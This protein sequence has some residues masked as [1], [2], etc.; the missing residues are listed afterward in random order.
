MENKKPLC[1]TFSGAIGSSKTPIA[2]YLSGK[3]NL[4]V[5][6]N[7]ALRSEIIGD[8][9]F[10]DEK[11]HGELKERRIK[12]ILE[13]RISFICDASVDRQWETL[14]SWLQKYDYDFFIISLDLSKDF[15][16][17]LHKNK[18]KYE[19]L[20]RLD[21]FMADHNLFIDKHADEISLHI[22][23]SNFKDRLSLAYK[24]V[25]EVFNF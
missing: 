15:L 17:K 5:F 3:L 13:K 2:N 1:I 14:K 12:E 6:N 25:S 20:L 9:G 4:P 24:A 19:S 18:G 10:L 11:V 23:D 22:N 16:I 21:K 7:D 8:L